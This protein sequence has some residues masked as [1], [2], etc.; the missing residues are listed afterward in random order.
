MDALRQ[1]AQTEGYET[2]VLDADDVLDGLEA[3]LA[4]DIVEDAIE[5]IL[6]GEA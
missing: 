6:E 2:Y 5:D 3:I 4:A 1:R